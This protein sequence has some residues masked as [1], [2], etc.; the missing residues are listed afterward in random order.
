M[1]VTCAG[2]SLTYA[3]L[4]TRSRA[5]AGALTERA[6]GIEDV[7]GLCA[8]RSLDQVVGLLGILRAGAAYLPL[9]PDLPEGRL[10]Y[11]VGDAGARLVLATATT[12]GLVEGAVQIS[13]LAGSGL[14]V[15]PKPQHAAYVI[16]TSGSTGQPK[17]VLTEHRAIVNRIS[18][19]QH[20]YP[21]GVDDAVLHKT[22]V[23][24]DVSVW[25]LLWPLVSGA[26][27]VLAEPGGHRDTAYLRDVI[28]DE[29]VTTVHFVPSMLTMFLGETGL[30]E[31]TSL[32]RLFSGGERLTPDLVRRVDEVLGVPMFNFY[33][34]AEAAVEVC[35]WP[36]AGL[37]L[38]A[39]TVPLGPPMGGVDVRV[40]DADL[41]PV[42]FGA[43]GEICIGGLA[44]ARG[45]VG[46]PELTA[47]SFVPD[48][49]TPGGRLYRS[50]D[51][52]RQRP[53]GVIEFLG[54]RD[55]QIKLRGQRL[56]RGE[57]EAVIRELAGVAAA[58]AMVREDLPGG[59]TLVG[60]AVP[61][62][63]TELTPE[64]LREGV[65]RQL[66]ET[67]VPA[68]FVVLLELPV[69]PTG[70]LDRGQLPKPEVARVNAADRTPPTTPTQ[71]AIAA[72]WEHL[73]GIEDV[74]LDDDFFALGGHSLLAIQ[75]VAR[76]RG[77]LPEGA[78][79]LSVMDVFRLRT[80]R[81]LAEHADAADSGPHHL[82][83]ELTRGV[84]VPALTVIAVPHGGGSAV[85][86]QGTA[87]SLPSGV[88]LYALAIP[89]HDV[90]VSEEALP[91]DELAQTVCDEVVERIEGPVVLYGHCGVGSAVIVELALRLEAA[92]RPVD[93]VYIGG[94]FPFARPTG[95]FGRLV[96]LVESERLTS[97]RSYENWMRALGAD[98]S[99]LDPEQ[100]RF[101]IHNV[102]RDS[103]TAETY[104]TEL[105]ES[106]PQVL[107][108]PVI[109]VVGEHDPATDYATERYRE[110]HRISRTTALVELPEAG[111]YFVKYRPDDLAE[112]ITEVHPGLSSGEIAAT[113]GQARGS[114]RLVD[115]SR[116]VDQAGGPRPSMGRFGIVA[117]TQLVSNLGSALTDFALPLWVFLQTHSV[118]QY[119]ILFTLA[120]VPGLIAAPLAGAVVDRRKRKTVMLVADS[121][122]G[123]LEAVLAVLYFTGQLEVWH[124]YGLVTAMSVALTF[125]RLAYQ[126]AI[127]QLVPKRFLGHAN[128]LVQ[129]VG[130]VAQ[131]LV[132]LV[133]VAVMAAVEL[134]GIIAIDMT[135]FVFA[136]VVLVLVAFPRTLPFTRRESLTHEMREG[137]QH[138]TRTSGFRAMLG[139]FALLN[140][141]LSP[142][143]LL[144]SPL[145][146]GFSDIKAVGIVSAAGGVGAFLG[147]LVLGIWGGPRTHKMR[148]VLWCAVAIAACAFI[149][150]LSPNAV[151]VA[152]GFAGLYFWLSVMNGIYATIV[153]TKVPPRFHGR[154]FAVQ[155]L[156]AWSTLPLAFLVVAPGL[157]ALMEPLMMPGGALADTL[158]R[159]IGT[160]PG[161]GVAALYLICSLVITAVSLVSLATPR[162]ANLDDEMPDAIS[163]DVIGLE[164]LG[165]P[166]EP[167][168]ELVRV[169]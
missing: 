39:R 107:T 26:R 81:E 4:T 49:F 19:M 76:L 132:P 138:A 153:Q 161:R 95:F 163:D 50:G 41:A 74:V 146:L 140:V 80:L 106:S 75:V 149:A 98:L 28:R 160:G 148:A 18:W 114:W 45:Y 137:F 150:G 58:S 118:T 68:A 152:V 2:R 56:E 89:G 131:L 145:V 51:L 130:G 3:E 38:D 25:E 46:R 155:T 16:Y 72:A 143:V 119:A 125:H 13:E 166:V 82:L 103:R 10:A 109:S 92:G 63:G 167:A 124:V 136:F 33:G 27:L 20:L 77:T 15:V 121:V 113:P 31:L 87:D 122:A 12:A 134:G 116:Q 65:A 34:P 100:A 151:P 73:L 84:A 67:Q 22:P 47:A 91:F 135:T 1:A 154:V 169:T 44:P 8:E 105:F 57:V 32:R 164:E 120:M 159:L 101:I 115:V 52:G 102:R 9:D 29:R 55:A 43:V 35:E 71:K 60:Y 157:S 144:L 42:P 7:V 40:L 127:P 48:P 90:G 5:V 86:Y 104:F 126:S 69:G 156:A 23:G 54:R 83:H 94:S 78:R 11:L 24:F 123:V 30:A 162:L 66:P 17:G 96:G 141:F 112:I 85:I 110:Y 14:P 142:M 37:A 108:A 133:A 61:R 99:D 70:K 6:I 139:W 147:G 129:M 128:G 168:T 88:A 64:G 117:S 158:G 111:H 62:A 93:A 36:T 53:D 79:P 97:D 21:L 59:P 165:L